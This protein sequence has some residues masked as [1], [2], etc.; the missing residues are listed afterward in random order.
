M[1]D[2]GAVYT[3]TVEPY[4]PG[5]VLEWNDPGGG[6]PMRGGSSGG[7]CNCVFYGVN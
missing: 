4:D 7:G 6:V 1:T 3:V 2:S 5:G